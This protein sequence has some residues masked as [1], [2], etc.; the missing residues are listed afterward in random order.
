MFRTPWLNLERDYIHRLPIQPRT[1]KRPR[2]SSALLHE[3]YLW[4]EGK[5]VFPSTRHKA[6]FLAIVSI[7][8]H[9]QVQKPKRELMPDPQGWGRAN[10]P[11]LGPGAQSILVG[12]KYTEYLRKNSQ[13]GDSSTSCALSSHYQNQSN[14][15]ACDYMCTES[16][17][18]FTLPTLFLKLW[19]FPPVTGFCPKRH[20]LFKHE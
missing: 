12:K 4:K 16:D 10:E 19:G 20:W 9:E 13:F 14:M 3:H 1:P 6:R 18:S 11:R 7:K 15:C 2:V 5:Q 8:A 17:H